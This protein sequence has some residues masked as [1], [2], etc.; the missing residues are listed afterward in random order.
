MLR[1]WFIQNRREIIM[2]L[3]LN[4]CVREDSRTKRLT[5]H[6]LAKLDDS[7]QEVRL[8][9]IRFPRVDEDF[10]RHRDR[11]VAERDYSDEIFDYAKTFA[12]A[13]TI[14]V[15]APFWDLSFPSMLK[16]YFEQINV[17]GLTFVYS[18]DGIPQGL[19]KAKTLYYVTTAGGPIYSEE[20]GYGYVKA[21]AQTFYGIPETTLFKADGL[22][23]YGA[24][25]EGILHEAE[26]QIDSAF[27][28]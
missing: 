15:A 8:S 23:I 7:V 28:S 22:D 25:V 3:F 16:Q 18:A 12:Q 19:C 20:Y 14:I 27:E 26:N 17:L 6:L 11:C 10:L 4:A 21:L 9:E 24:D 1:S 13:D 5:D 2:I